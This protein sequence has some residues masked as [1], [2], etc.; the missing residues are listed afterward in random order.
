MLDPKTNNMFYFNGP[1]HTAPNCPVDMAPNFNPSF[2]AQSYRSSNKACTRSAYYN[3]PFFLNRP[4][5]KYE[6]W[7]INA[8]EARP[9]HH[10][11]V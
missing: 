8:H 11:Q 3:I 2:G 1:K 9:G 10:T 4:G 6:E 5:P 7:S